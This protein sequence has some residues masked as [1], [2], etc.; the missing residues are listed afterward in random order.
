MSGIV[1][2]AMLSAS[3][4]V[5]TMFGAVDEVRRW[6]GMLLDGLGLGPRQQPSRVLLATPAFRVRSYPLVTTLAPPVLLVAAPIK[7]AYIWDLCPQVSTVGLLRD[8][9]FAVYLLEWLDP[10]GSDEDLGL[11]GYADRFIRDAVRAVSQDC[12]GPPVL[13]GH[14][15][16]GTLAAIFCSLHPDLVSGVVL[17]EA[18]LHLGPAAGAFAPVV[19][20]STDARWLQAGFGTVPG[21]LLDLVT[22]IAAPREFLL[23]RYAELATSVGCPELWVHLRV[24]RWTLDELALPGRL[25]AQVIEYLYREDRFMRGELE[26]A[27]RRVGAGS[28]VVPMLNVVNPRNAAVPASSIVP[29]HQAAASES[30]KLLLYHGDHGVALQHVGALVGGNARASLWPE[31]VCWIRDRLTARPADPPSQGARQG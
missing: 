19:A 29:F 21:S 24:E 6:H 4:P 26:I 12:G 18:P 10:Q 17:L 22:S 1:G 31:I 30:K 13:V 2:L 15:I 27:G 3:V 8:A 25:F 5:Q 28:L 11:D 7:R 23:E 14:S 16:G 9:G 20:T